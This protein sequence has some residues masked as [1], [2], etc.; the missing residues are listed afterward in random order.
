MSMHLIDSLPECRNLASRGAAEM[1]QA[2]SL[3]CPLFIWSLKVF[4]FFS[5]LLCSQGSQGCVLGW[6]SLVSLSRAL[7]ESF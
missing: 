7:E 3:L 5:G 4:R 2:I 6:V 1:T